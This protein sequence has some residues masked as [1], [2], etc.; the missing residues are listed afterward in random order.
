MP[1]A[2]DAPWSKAAKRNVPEPT[3][4]SRRTPPVNIL[5]QIPFPARPRN[6]FPEPQPH[7]PDLFIVRLEDEDGTALRFQD[8]AG[9]PNDCLHHV[10]PLVF[11]NTA[12]LAIDL[13]INGVGYNGIHAMGGQFLQ[14]L[15]AISVNERDGLDPGFSINRGTSNDLQGFCSGPV[16]A[17]F[18]HGS[19]ATGYFAS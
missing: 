15:A 12:I 11:G 10:E 8:S 6:E 13:G 5:H 16:L 1:I 19:G 3:N 7:F 9:F 18:S 17:I 2:F 4:G 14:F